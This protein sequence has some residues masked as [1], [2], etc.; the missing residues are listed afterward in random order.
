MS[1]TP[2]NFG[3]P[4]GVEKSVFFSQETYHSQNFWYETLKSFEKTKC[5]SLL[6]HRHVKVT[7]D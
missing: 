2:G 5:V 7:N 3:C 1:E 4:N 6:P